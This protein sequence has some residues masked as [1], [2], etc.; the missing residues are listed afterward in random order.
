MIRKTEIS[1]TEHTSFERWE[2]VNEDGKALSASTIGTVDSRFCGDY[3]KTVTIGGVGTPPEYRRGGKVREVFETAFLEAPERGWEVSV[4]HPFSFSYYR[5]F[6]Y[7]KVADHLIVE[8]PITALDFLPR[9]NDLVPINGDELVP[10]M[11][12]V[13]EKFAE[14]RNIM[15]RRFDSEK[16]PTEPKKERYAYIYYNGSEPEG[17]LIL[18]KE[19]Y[20]CINRMDGVYLHVYE[21]AYTNPDALRKLLGFIRM[22]DGEFNNV[23]F[24]NIAMAPEVE[25]VL[26]HYTHTKYT[27]VSDIMARVLDVPMM[28]M[29]Q[30]YPM[31]CVHFTVKVIDTL[32]FTKGA[33]E[34]EYENGKCAVKRIS[35]DATCDLEA[36]MPAF[37]ALLY[38]YDEY[39]PDNIVYMHDVK[40][41]NAGSDLFKVFHRKYNGVFEHF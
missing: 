26:R 14:T 34:V 20:F 27:R 38:G 31:E 16:F 5:K 37:T 21:I 10:D 40:L 18:G 6:G 24:H 22:Y 12:K 4:L 30:K 32:P 9:Y 7:E 28:L 39:T 1:R 8:F 25:M 41:N 17:Y 29:H 11:I 23:K 15:L 3:V 36:A 33:Y 19:S 35:D 2:I 13:Y